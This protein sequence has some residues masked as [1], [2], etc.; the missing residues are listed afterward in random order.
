M[1]TLQDPNSVSA[2]PKDPEALREHFG[3][4]LVCLR[5]AGGDTETRMTRESFLRMC[6]SSYDEVK[7]G[8]KSTIGQTK[9]CGFC[10][11]GSQVADKGLE[12]FPENIKWIDVSEVE[13]LQRSLEQL[14]NSRPRASK[15]PNHVAL[16]ELETFF[17]LDTKLGT[18]PNQALSESFDD[19]ESLD[20]LDSLDSLELAGN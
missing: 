5:L 6:K 17:E 11:V 10:L 16:A 8:R 14:E 3:D 12:V 18:A 13:A 2:L 1:K 4:R 20:D 15:L 7:S 19:L 9:P